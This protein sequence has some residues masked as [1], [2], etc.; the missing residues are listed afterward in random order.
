MKRLLL[1]VAACATVAASTFAAHVRAQTA[2][3]APAAF[4]VASIKPNKT[5]DGRVMVGMAPGGR[6]TAT[7]IP[8]QFLI[9]QAFNIQD[10]QIVGAP[11][12]LRSDRFDVVA[13]AP[14]GDGN[15][16]GEQMRP[17][18]RALLEERFKLTSHT[19]TR[20]MGIY[21]LVKARA[22]GKLGASLAPAATDCAAARGRRAG[23]PP[24]PLPQ[25]GQKINCG[26]MMGPGKLNAG[27][28]SMS[29]LARSLSQQ[30]GRV[31]VD[32]TGLTGGFDF[33]LTYTPV[34]IGTG[35]PLGA[36]DGAPVAADPNAPNL[37]TALQ[38]QLGLKL[39]SE[40]GPVEVLVIDHIEQP[41]AD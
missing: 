10:F 2:P 26:L 40:R 5:G 24:P 31:V 38:E 13:K 16:T 27:G 9:R 23:G 37:F 25:P 18:V 21:A 35:G 14:E 33:E 1:V 11:D 17:M 41:V 15:I 19:E 32:K 6:F 3:A 8:A 20:E 30:V 36:P 28:T 34:Q 12:W 29:E 39:D 7:N 22:D 4:E